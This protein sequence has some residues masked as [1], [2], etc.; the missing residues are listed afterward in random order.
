MKKVDYK[1]IK[2]EALGDKKKLDEEL[3]TIKERAL[4]AHKVLDRLKKDLDEASKRLSV[5][6]EKSRQQIYSLRK[7][8]V[9]AETFI[10]DCENTICELEAM[11]KIAG[12]MDTEKIEKVS[13]FEKKTIYSSVK[14]LNQI[15]TNKRLNKMSELK[16]IRVDYNAEVDPF[17]I[18]REE[19]NLIEAYV[20][21]CI[22]LNSRGDLKAGFSLIEGN[23]EKLMGA[24][25]GYD[26][27]IKLSGG[28]ILKEEFNF[29]KT[30]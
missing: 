1:K 29:K 24:Q 25:K 2:R 28:K 27:Q 23:F 15:C 26:E 8:I 16:E 14:S 4:Y 12:S 13:F 5:D 17:E 3:E 10:M 22:G 19:G 30:A 7:L 21:Y 18:M 6:P 11:K 9:G 20:D